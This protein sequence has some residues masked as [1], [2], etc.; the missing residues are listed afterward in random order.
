MDFANHRAAWRG[1]ELSKSPST[2]QFRLTPLQ[3]QEL[4]QVAEKLASTKSDNDLRNLKPADAPLP[5][6]EQ[7]LMEWSDQLED[8]RGF[9]LLRG[10]EVDKWPTRVTEAAYLALGC[11][12]GVFVSQNSDGDLLGNIK[13]DGSDPN[14]PTVRLYRTR[15][16]QPFHVDGSD[17]VGLLCLKTAKS[18][19]KSSIVSSVSI[20]N[21]VVRRKPHLEKLM[22]ELYYFDSYGQHKP[23]EDPWFKLPL[24]IGSKDNFRMFYIPW[25][26]T[27]CQQNPAAPRLRPEQV[28]LLNL[29][30]ELAASDELR[31]DMD[32]QPGD[33]QLLSNR[34]ILHAREGYEDWPEP[35]RK[36]HL[37]RLWITLHRHTVNGQGSGGIEK[38]EGGIAGNK[39][40]VFDKQE[41]SKM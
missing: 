37:L 5:S 9:I 12:L 21:E 3:N 17:A 32:F 31:L 36:R 7:E 35:E 27:K 16:P 2:W 19:G 38:K 29:I 1:S 26:I 13:D 10:L 40:L 4:R 28:E 34:V 25:Y 6:L 8:G 18:G 15:E 30:D 14:D 11:H 39:A 41:S 20:Y 24:F 33:I 23:G 22:H